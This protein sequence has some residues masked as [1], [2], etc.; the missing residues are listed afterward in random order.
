MSG[1]AAGLRWPLGRAMLLAA[2]AALAWTGSAAAQTPERW[3][4]TVPNGYDFPALADPAQTVRIDADLRLPGG[5]PRAVVILS[6][7]SSG[8]GAHVARWAAFLHAEGYATLAIDHFGGRGVRS[9]AAEQIGVSEQQMMSDVLSAAAALRA[10]PRFATTPIAQIG[11]SKGAT[12]GLLASVERFA[13]FAG[14]TRLDLVVAFYPFCGVWLDGDASTR[15]RVLAGA[16]DDW[17]PA[18]PCAEAVAA[19]SAGGSDAEIE[20]FDGAAHGFDYWDAA[21]R[22]IDGAVTVRDASDRCALVVGSDGATRTA[23]GAHS[24][25]TRERR[26]AYLRTCGERGVGFGGAPELRATVEDRV[27]RALASVSVD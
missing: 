11:W 20:V 19:L 7:G 4:A 10:D 25:A 26:A 21:P 8:Q 22:R 24:V 9:T 1:T 27:L 5:P 17:T 14:E 6:H 3:S 15:L 13:A 2:A 16:D 23:D 12:A 18:A